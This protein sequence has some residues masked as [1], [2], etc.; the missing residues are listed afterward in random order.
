MALKYV[1]PNI[2][3]I[4][5][6]LKYVGKGN[7]EQRRVNGCNT[8]LSCSYNLYF[9]IQGSEDIVVIMP[10]EVGEKYFEVKKKVKLINQRITLEGYK[11][12]NGG[13]TNYILNA[14]DMVEV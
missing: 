7:I 12:G 4:L 13:F 1:V 14:D 8:I 5:G 11:I 3:R 10:V 6:N 2:K 9:N